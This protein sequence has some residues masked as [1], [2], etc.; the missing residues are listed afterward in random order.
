MHKRG[1]SQFERIHTEACLQGLP[2]LVLR[3][4]L[5]VR[6]QVKAVAGDPIANGAVGRGI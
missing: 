4:Q 6:C 2:Y 5:H 1:R 3:V